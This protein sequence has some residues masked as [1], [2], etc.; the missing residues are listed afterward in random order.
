MK[1]FLIY[2]EQPKENLD[3]H[4]YVVASSLD[5]A[6]NLFRATYGDKIV[7]QSVQTQIHN[8]LVAKE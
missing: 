8:A 1:G 3:K 4:I 7:I 5:A 6:I 2:Y